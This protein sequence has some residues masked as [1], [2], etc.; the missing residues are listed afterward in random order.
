MRASRRDAD[1]AETFEDLR[2]G[3]RHLLATADMQLGN[4]PTAAVQNRWV[5]QLGVLQTALDRLDEL[6][7]QW[8]ETRDS[9]PAN[10]KPGTPLFDDALAEHHAESWTYLD[11]WACH[12]HTL[13][14]IN[15]AARNTPSPLAPPPTT[16]PAPDRRTPVRR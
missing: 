12:G 3:A 11:D 9:L 10:A 4:L 6:H 2:A 5:Y 7:E 16:V 1:T 14:E 8:R 13:R 15:S